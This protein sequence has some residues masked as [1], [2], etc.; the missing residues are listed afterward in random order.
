MKVS[1]FAESDFTDSGYTWVDFW[2]DESKVSG[3]YIT[4]DDEEEYGKSV[5]VWFDGGMVTLKQEPNLI[6]FLEKFL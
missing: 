3:F 4:T 2:I 5:N 6:K 1:L